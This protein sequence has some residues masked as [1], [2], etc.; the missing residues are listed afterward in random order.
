MPKASIPGVCLLFNKLT[1]PQ[2]FMKCHTNCELSYGNFDIFFKNLVIL[3]SLQFTV[4]ECMFGPTTFMSIRHWHLISIM[5]PT[6][7]VFLS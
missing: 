3:F 4:Q 6:A 1:V 2:Y 5:F 7:S